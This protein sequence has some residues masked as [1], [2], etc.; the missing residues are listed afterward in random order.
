MGSIVHRVVYRVLTI[1]FSHLMKQLLQL[2]LQLGKVHGCDQAF[3]GLVQTV[4]NQ[5]D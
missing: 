1:V 3:L 4:S 2:L 5:L